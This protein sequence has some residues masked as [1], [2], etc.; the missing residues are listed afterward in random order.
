MAGAAA[1]KRHEENRKRLSLLRTLLLVGI[2]CQLTALAWAIKGQ[3]GA[4]DRLP[5]WQIAR[6][7]GTACVGL[8]CYSTISSIAAPIYG[9]DGDLL[10]GGGDLN[11]G[12][13]NGYAHDVLYITAF[14]QVQR[15]AASRL[16][17]LP[18]GFTIVMHADY[19][20]CAEF[21]HAQVTT[22]LSSY[23]WYTYLTV[24]AYAAY[25]FVQLVRCCGYCLV[26]LHGHGPHVATRPC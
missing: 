8:A 19:R 25:K 7:I 10:D 5:G 20:L 23:F 12:G 1:K 21:S 26:L 16:G 4:G 15:A 11:R 3:G 24:P 22:L 18:T 2:G 6:A 9:A 13:I 14:V 17:M